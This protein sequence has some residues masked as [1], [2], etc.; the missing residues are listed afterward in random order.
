MN[1]PGSQWILF[2]QPKLAMDVGLY[3]ESLNL[4]LK[5][6]PNIGPASVTLGGGGAFVGTLTN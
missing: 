2:I 4:S 1:N 5:I 6:G 3:Q